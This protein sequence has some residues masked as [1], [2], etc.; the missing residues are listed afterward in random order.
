MSDVISFKDKEER[1]TLIV[2]S[3]FLEQCPNP[4]KHTVLELHKDFNMITYLHSETAPAVIQHKQLPLDDELKKLVD[5]GEYFYKVTDA[6]RI[7]YWIDGH[8]IS[9]E[10][11]IRAKKLHHELGFDKKFNEFIES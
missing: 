10:D 2:K 7:E 8:C 9:R 1:F 4:S 5:N 11:P 3:K 6:G